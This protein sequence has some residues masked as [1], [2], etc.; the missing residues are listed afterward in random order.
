MNKIARETIQTAFEQLDATALQQIA[1]HCS[2]MYKLART[3]NETTSE[4]LDFIKSS[5]V[6]ALRMLG[7]WCEKAITIKQNKEMVIEHE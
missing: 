7:L 4:K 5:E 2:G 6:D 1:T 3:F